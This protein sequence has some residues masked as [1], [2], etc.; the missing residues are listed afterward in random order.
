MKIF[1]LFDKKSGEYSCIS[2]EK[3]LAMFERSLA[4]Q[5]NNPRSTNLLYT[6]A[7]DFDIYCLGEFDPQTGNIIS[8]VSFVRNCNEL[9]ED[10]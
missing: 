10:V 3:N 6:N 2:A 5:I 4:Q 7:V 1:C 8:S 9:K